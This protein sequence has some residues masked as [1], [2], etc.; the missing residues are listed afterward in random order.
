MSVLWLLLGFLLV[1]A[2][3]NSLPHFSWT[4]L[5]TAF[6]F[7]PLQS[8]HTSLWLIMRAGRDY[9]YHS[10]SHRVTCP[11]LWSESPWPETRELYCNITMSHSAQH[12]RHYVFLHIV[13]FQIILFICTRSTPT[14]PHMHANTHIFSLYYGCYPAPA[15]SVQWEQPALFVRNKGKWEI[16]QGF[17]SGAITQCE[18]CVPVCVWYAATVWNILAFGERCVLAES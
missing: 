11:L 13:L 4:I 8:V 9:G 18:K 6:S 16:K 14:H 10:D 7:A 3:K 15:L 12:W 17:V 5:V 2:A 1:I